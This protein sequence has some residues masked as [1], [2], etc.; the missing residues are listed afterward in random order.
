MKHRVHA[1]DPVDEKYLA[2]QNYEPFSAPPVLWNILPS[3]VRLVS[4]LL[5]FQ[6]SLKSGWDIKPGV[7]KELVNY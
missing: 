5:T 4:S 2:G 3:E 1:M 7:V 6:R